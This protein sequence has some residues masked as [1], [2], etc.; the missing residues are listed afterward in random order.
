MKKVIF[1]LISILIFSCKDNSTTGNI[2]DF[3]VRKVLYATDD[4]NSELFLYDLESKN[5]EPLNIFENSN[6]AQGKIENIVHFG[7]DFY[8]IIPDANK[9][10]VID[11]EDYNIINELD[12]GSSKPFDIAFA[13]NATTAYVIHKD[14]D[15]VS[16]VDITTYELAGVIDNNIS[17]PSDLVTDGNVLFVANKNDNTVSMFSTMNESLLNKFDVAPRPVSLNVLNTD[18]SLLVISAGYGKDGNVEDKSPAV[19]TYIEPTTG[20]VQS[21]YNIEYNNVKAVDVVPLKSVNTI[22]DYVFLLEQNY[23]MFI[24][25]RTKKDARLFYY[26]KFD[27]IFYNILDDYLYLSIAEGNSTKVIMSETTTN[28]VAETVIINNRISTFYVVK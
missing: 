28:E 8:L 5:S 11:D 6:I 20:V 15:I 12:F 3:E 9:I 10:Y 13:E 26:Q 21:T 27:D 18:K 22:N 16:V 7:T 2:T 19:A 24:N 4:V 1:V 17:G 14:E 25:A 23:I